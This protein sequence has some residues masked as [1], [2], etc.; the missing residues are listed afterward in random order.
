MPYADAQQMI[1]RFDERTLK[2]LCSDTGTAETNLSANARIATALDDASGEI[3]SACQVGK[4][5]SQEDLDE[6]TQTPGTD[7]SLLRRICCELALVHLIEAR[8]E[9][10]KGAVDGLRKRTEEYLDKF[11][12][13][14]R[15]F[16][17]EVNKNAGVVHHAGLNNA[18]YDQ[19]RWL[20]DRCTGFYPN[21]NLPLGR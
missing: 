8:P 3:D 11:R 19:Q 21:R 6:L 15:V 17:I 12:R 16:N 1:L 20:R 14:V 10:F 18:E 7:R 13:G 2:D 9:K 5:Y 4:M